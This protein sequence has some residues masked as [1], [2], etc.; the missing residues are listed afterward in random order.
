MVIFP[1]CGNYVCDYDN[2]IPYKNIQESYFKDW[3]NREFCILTTK[4]KYGYNNKR[5]CGHNVIIITW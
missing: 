2:G 4:C 5:D 3:G 1:D